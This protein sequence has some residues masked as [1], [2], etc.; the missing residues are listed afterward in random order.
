MSGCEGQAD[1]LRDIEEGPIALMV[2]LGECSYIKMAC[3][4]KVVGARLCMIISDRRDLGHVGEQGKIGLRLD[5]FFKPSG[6]VGECQET[7]KGRNRSK[8]HSMPCSW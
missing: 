4:L 1:S 3:A 2:E 8:Y 5:L 6:P 7:L